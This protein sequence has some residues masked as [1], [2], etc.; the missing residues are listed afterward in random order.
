MRFDGRANDQRPLVPI[1]T[2]VLWLVCLAVGAGGLYLQYPHPDLPVTPMEPVRADLI[3]ADISKASEPKPEMGAV[4][5]SLQTPDQPPTTPSPPAEAPPIN[6]PSAPPLAAVAAPS[7]SIAFAQPVEAAPRPA[8]AP[9]KV[10]PPSPLAPRQLTYGE[11]EGDQPSPEYPLEAQ[12]AR[13]EGT[14]VVRFT[15]GPNGRVQKVEANVPSPWPL[16]NQSAVRAVRETWSRPPARR[17][18]PGIYEVPIE[19]KHQ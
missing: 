1:A 9:A 16:L 7:P 19:F 3:K 5:D 13:Q 6:V 17:L 12:L 10:A 2:L 11:G 4:S 8:S 14:V 15:V 18:Q